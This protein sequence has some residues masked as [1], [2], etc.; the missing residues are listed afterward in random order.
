MEHIRQKHEQHISPLT[1]QI[2]G[3]ILLYQ[4]KKLTKKLVND[5]LDTIPEDKRKDA[6][7][8]LEIGLSH[9]IDNLPE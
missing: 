8:Q 5:W 4:D 3:M 2:N 9:G 7:Y 1:E 6:A